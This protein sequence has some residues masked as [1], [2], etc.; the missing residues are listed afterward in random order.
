[1]NN[2]LA[3]ID[4]LDIDGKEDVVEAVKNVADWA[5]NVRGDA[6]DIVK[7]VYM[8]FVTDRL[9]MFTM[10]VNGNTD[11][12]FIKNYIDNMMAKDAQEYREYVF[13]NVPGVNLNIT[14]PVPE[15]MGGGSFET[16]LSI[17]ETIFA[18]V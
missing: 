6:E 11:R 2:S 1:M 9:C 16:F 8:T 17:G 10:S 7:N 15:S 13:S 3:I 18:N 14:I 12:D 5:K 4:S